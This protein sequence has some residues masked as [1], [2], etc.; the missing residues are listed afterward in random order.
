MNRSVKKI[1]KAG[2]RVVT[3]I[4]SKFDSVYLADDVP[5]PSIVSHLNW[6]KHLVSVGNERGKRILELGSREVC[7]PSNARQEFARAQYVGFD[8]Y[9]GN[10]VDVVG[11]A[12]KLSSYF[13]EGA[14][15]DIIYTSA[16]FEHFALPWIVAVEIAKLLKV[17]GLVFVETHFSF[18]SHERPWNFF[19]FSDMGLRALFPKHSG[20]S[21]STRECPI[22]SSD[23]SRH[24]PPTTSRTRW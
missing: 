11:D 15:F 6:K 4:E 14:K 22:P 24:W 17:G 18:S 9:P 16:C 1:L 2:L 21:V 13:E 19:Q 10:N 5:A 3:S 12:H 7:G 8:F 23:A 20:S